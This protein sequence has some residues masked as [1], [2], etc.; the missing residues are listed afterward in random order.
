MKKFYFLIFCFVLFFG[1][2]NLVGQIVWANGAA[3]TAWY[4]AANW[5]PSTAFGAWT[6]SSVA[7]FQNTGS[8]T[9]AGINMNTLQLSIG[10]IEI[11]SAR[12]RALTIGNSSTTA[13]T[14]TLNGTTINSVSN[15]ILRN[16]CGFLMTL[17][18]NETGSGKTMNIALANTTTNVISIDGA[19]GI[20]ISS[21]ISGSSKSLTKG[22]SGAGVLT[23]SGA[24]TYNGG[25]TI[26][27]GTLAF[28]AS[29][30]LADAGGLTFAGGTL[31]TGGFNE[32]VGALDLSA[33][34]SSITLAASS[35]S[36]T[37]SSAPASFTSSSAT[38]TITGWTGTAYGAAGTN[39]RIFCGSTLTAA[40]LAKITFSGGTY[41]GNATQI[42]GGEIVPVAACAN[43]TLTAASQAAATVCDGAGATINLTGLVANS[44]NNAID[45]TIDGVAA[46]QVT[47]IAADASGNA[48][49]TTRNLV[50]A[51]DNGK[52]L[53]ITKITNSSCNTNFTVN[54]TNPLVVTARPTVAFSA[55]P[56]AAA[57]ANT[58][59]TYTIATSGGE[60]N[61]IWNVPNTYSITSGGIGTGSSTVT[62]KYTDAGSKTV[63]IN[64]T[65]GGC[66]AASATSSTATT[67]TLVAPTFTAQPSSPSC[68]GTD[69]V[70]TTQSGKSNYVWTI[71]GDATIQSGGGTS[72][73]TVTV[74]Y[75]TAG[76]KTVTV[77]YTDNSCTAASA[78]SSNSITVNAPASTPTGLTGT[79]TVCQ[80]QNTVAYSVT[81]VAG[82]T[83][84]WSYTGGTGA[85][86]SGSGNSITY[87][88]SSSATSGQVEVT[89]ATGGC[90]ASTAAT[91]A[92]TVNPLPA[93]PGA[94]TT[95]TSTLCAGT[96]GV[97][98]EVPFA[99]DATS[100]YS[101]SYVGGSNATINSGTTRSVTVDF[102]SNATSGTLTVY[103]N[104]G[105][106]A[107]ASA[108]TIAVTVNPLLTPAV[109]ITASPS[110]AIC[111]GTSVTFTPGTPTNLGGGSVTGPNTYEWFL[112][113]V[114]QGAPTA[115]F[116]SNT[117]NNNDQIYARMTVTGGT[118]C[119]TAN[120]VNSNTITETVNPIPS[121][122]SFSTSTTTTCQSIS[123]V[124]YIVNNSGG[125]Y[126]W[127]YTG[128][129]GSING[130]TNSI[131]INY[132]ATA[133]SGNLNV[134]TTVSGCNSSTTSL[135]ITVN[136][137]ISITTPPSS[138]TISAGSNTSFSV[139]A[140][141][142]ASGGYQWQ[143]N[144]GSGFNNVVDDAVYSGSNSAT[145]NL[146]SVPNS[147]SGYTYQCILTGLTS[148]TQ[149]TTP[150]TPATLTVKCLL[151][152]FTSA[153]FPPAGWLAT[154]CARSTTAADYV[155]SP[156][157]AIFQPANGTL[158]LPASAY[159]QSM[160][161]Y[162]GRTNTSSD[163][164]MYVNVSTV[165]QTGPFTTIAI[166]D[167][168]GTSPNIQ[169]P[170]NTY[171]QYTVNF[172][173]Y[174]SYP[175]VWVQFQKVSTST[176]LWR[177]DDINI[178]CGTGCTQP[179]V[180]TQPT[181]QTGCVSTTIQFTAAT[182]SGSPTYQWEMAATNAVGSLW[183]NVANSTPSGVTYTNATTGTLSISG[184]SSVSSYYY[185]CK[186]ISG[187][188]T[189]Y[190]SA[191]QLGIAAVPSITTSP[192]NV[193]TS[194]SQ[195]A[196]FTVT[197]TGSPL[198]YQWQEKV[199]AGAF[200]NISDGGYF[201]GTGTATLSVINPIL[202][203][204]TNQY[205][206][207][208]SSYNCAIQTSGA[209]TLTV[210]TYCVPSITL[211]CDEFIYNVTFNTI[212]NT[213]ANYVCGITSGTTGYSDYSATSTSVIK[214][215]TYSLSVSVGK[216]TDP[217]ASWTNNDIR[218]WAD[219]NADGDF[220]D[221]GET[222]VSI[223]NNGASG[224]YNI[225]IPSTATTGNTR[226]RVR[227]TYADETDPCGAATYGETEDYTLA[228][229]AP[230][231]PQASV[232]NFYP[233]T[234]PAGTIINVVGTGFSNTTAVTINGVTATYTIVSSTQLNVEV[235][236]AAGTGVI[237]ITDNASCTYKTSSSFT[238]LNQ[239]GTCSG[240]GAYTDLII[241]EISDPV[242]GNNHYIEVYNGTSNT[243]NLNTPNNYTIQVY[244]DGSP[245][246]TVQSV[247]ISG[248][249]A[250]GG[251]KVYYAG[252]N[253][254]LATATAQGTS[255][256]F[257]DNDEIRLLKDGT[258]IDRVVTPNYVGYNYKR[259]TSVLSPTATY[260]SAQ[261]TITS[262]PVTQNTTNIGSF[263]PAV[264]ITISSPSDVNACS[265]TMS[266]TTTPASGLL[267]NWYYQNGTTGTGWTSLSNGAGSGAFAGTTI[268]GADG[269]S[270]SITGDLTNI[271]N[272]QFYCYTTDASCEKYSNAAQFTLNADR[273]FRTTGAGGNWTSASNWQMA[274][275]VGGPY[276]S[277]CTYPT[278]TNSDYIS[279]E[280]GT[281]MVLNP[282]TFTVDQLVIQSGGTL[283]IPSTT[284]LTINNGAA[285]AD[286][287]VLGTLID[288][289]NSS[290]NTSFSGGA[291]WSIGASGSFVK[292]NSSSSSVFQNNYEG[293]IATA[294][295]STANWI[296]RY[297]GASTQISLT[298]SNAVYPNLIFESNS[299]AWTPSTFSTKLT[300][301]T[302]ITVKGNLD[303]G[304]TGSG[305]VTGLINDNTNAAGISVAGDLI[306]R[307]GSSLTNVS[308]LASTYGVGYDVQG[309]VTINGTLTN[310]GGSTGILKLTGIQTS[311]QTISG[312]GTMD[313][314]NVTVNKT[315]VG[316]G[317]TMSRNMSIPTSGTLTISNGLLNAQTNTLDG[318]GDL[319]M[320]GG[321]LQ[322]SKNAVTQPELTGTYSLS[323]GTVILN[324]N[325][326]GANAQTVRA[327]NYYNL[328]SSSTGARILPSSGT[329]G[330]ASTFTPNFP[331]Q[332]YTITGSTVDFN[333]SGAAQN[334]PAFAFYN[335]G[336]KNGGT[337]TLIG[338]DTVYRAV[339]LGNSPTVSD[340]TALA[341]G[342]FDI[343]LHS[344]NSFTA[345]IGRTPI[346][347]G[348]ITYGTGRFNIERYLPMQT[349]YSGRRWRLMGVPISATNAPSIASSW[350]EGA[351][352]TTTTTDITASTNPNPTYGTH[353]TNGIGSTNN[354]TGFDAG[355]TA[356]PSIYKMNPG[357]G[358]WSVPSALNGS[359]AITDY[360]AYMLFVRGDRSI[361]VSSAY[362]NTTGGANLRIRGKINVGDV[363]TSIVANKQLLSNPY[364]SSI[365]LAGADYGGV[366]M[367]SAGGTGRTYY[368][369]DPKLLGSKNVGGFVTFSSNG[370]NTFTY[371][372]YVNTA[373]Y[374]TGISSYTT[375]GTIESGGAF[376]IDNTYGASSF[377]IHESDKKTTSTTVGLA[378]RPTGS[379]STSDVSA[380]Y[381][382][383]VYIDG[384]GTPILAD[385]VATLYADQYSNEVGSEDSKKMLTFQTREKISLLRN[386]SILAIERRESI[387]IEDTIFLQMN[388]LDN[389]FTYQLQFIGKNFKPEITAYLID[390][391]LKETYVIST[392][393]TSMHNFETDNDAGSV[394]INRF[395]IV[396]KLPELGTVPVTFTTVAASL[397]NGTANV[398]WK[399]ENETNIKQ[400]IVE[401]SVDGVNFVKAATL[402][403]NGNGQYN[404]ADA[405]VLTGVTYYRILSVSNTNVVK[406]SS[407][408]NVK[409]TNAQPAVALQ[410]N[411]VKDGIITLQLSNMPEGTYKFT[412]Y[413]SIGQVMFTKQKVVS[414][415]NTSFVVGQVTAKGIYH[416]E[417]L[418]PDRTKETIKVIY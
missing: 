382:N 97:A 199:G 100:D 146:T 45:Y 28:G 41:P 235:P 92:V 176:T 347:S 223:N 229:V 39:G 375:D 182:S 412:L 318:G 332:A 32:T 279:I 90:A 251:I 114:S 362:I 329:V 311:P 365:S 326:T 221:A 358:L 188:C 87:S 57:C 295:P 261:W 325:G 410:Q 380:F 320:T 269:I 193:L 312:S 10:S 154:N 74:R 366:I 314:F 78:T 11:T 150:S 367:G 274:T 85:T 49:F 48:S 88:F 30:V 372:P 173:G 206:C 270:L 272:Y 207:I 122:P 337:K 348:N 189:I 40:Q 170:G 215:Q 132:G 239:A 120:P 80:G 44:T 273:Y 67:V 317:V 145:L 81:N 234:G 51:T 371:V 118:G 284:T 53:Q 22:G 179:T 155:T 34:S 400:Y 345:Y 163:K 181:A 89:A 180:T 256:G 17:Q 354:A 196:T 357:S 263:T 184:I 59:L 27:A 407:I 144:T 15:V 330:I 124:A 68:T 19:G 294:M 310:N 112:N 254:G 137:K 160:T 415:T 361:V 116:T 96:S 213:S 94:F 262:E 16:N 335:V 135:G 340:G 157:A 60:S 281:T 50:Y 129:G 389:N 36:L 237:A 392:E 177:L 151:E 280:S 352:P 413:N 327:V 18:N 264:A 4:T 217:L 47:G 204:S 174:S 73:N 141:N 343:V 98:Y 220:A 303:I 106:G 25:T 130:S 84:A 72:D 414:G 222:M 296:L 360:K 127:A 43:P 322:V 321:S 307:S 388:R 386:D 319:T 341:L 125:T 244:N 249:I 313:L 5:S 91:Y 298:S 26:S 38:L 374:N 245:S 275:A 52:V 282:S 403:A 364:P 198:T 276:G 369:W 232:T 411:P 218:V 287:S 355:S 377:I 278:V 23:L 339:T 79:A 286:M 350:Q 46:T 65:K 186:I 175:N 370:N 7:Q 147:Y 103:A 187:G 211:A 152:S 111:F 212:N 378:S 323:G 393:G 82:V 383:L 136:P 238:S 398:E 216:A 171:A 20:T 291:T 418:K 190:T 183:S 9:T 247:D 172:G 37:F 268:A 42:A 402:A 115:T 404:F 253:G 86:L 6:T 1:T 266:V 117:L 13:G 399:V 288:S 231:T 58:D 236:S 260:N 242:S 333:G 224:A 255:N 161:F 165:S 99:A 142:V 168:N 331:T 66:P 252:A 208:V 101:W 257:N 271:N 373:P 113:G 338:S 178:T 153:T 139:T 308:N 250:P 226:L 77:N 292:T 246:G 156:A 105:C 258:V 305:T 346:P 408:V 93:Q 56:G 289:T 54:L 228:I 290:N 225:T 195:T 306:V 70:Y 14:L 227:L 33:G 167:E 126:T 285:G 201:S 240:A 76:S 140:S 134:Y 148:C 356:N 417:L 241:T 301:N 95:S 119:L 131:T 3:A 315:G 233:S 200:T 351:V 192:S 197:A 158:T 405:T 316:G 309:N 219:W 385:G 267:Y 353:I 83:Y 390:K 109:T 138:V 334:I 328:T 24:N 29:G 265:V 384:Q 359:T 342:N 121:A 107:S 324:G 166:Y 376:M 297:T 71:P 349:P 214:G 159:P 293:T 2:K 110:G 133:T 203:M 387:A 391:Y 8:A 230:C 299:G 185:R 202:S 191:A 12:T 336:F 302:V 304:G 64:Y 102:A 344:D 75:T 62:L 395:K 205:R 194:V 243:I 381:T 149:V 277:A 128:T 379:G 123:G 394:D 248:T 63:T 397:S 108:R 209:A 35:H 396:F 259:L 169:V 21:I 61:F 31:S 300:G 416:L 210:Q 162:L 143:V 104:N 55:Q 283:K 409:K 368:L 401:R 164:V 363:S 406:Y 69:L